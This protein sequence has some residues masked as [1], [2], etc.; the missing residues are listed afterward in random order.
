[1]T[2][3]KA[4]GAG[5]EGPRQASDFALMERICGRD[6]GALEEFYDRHASLV[7][8][9]CLRVLRDAREAEE[10]L[11]EV[12]LE[13]WRRVERY[14]AGRASPRVYL[15]QVSRSRALDRLRRNRRRSDL[16]RRA[17]AEADVGAD[18][19]ACADPLPIDDAIAAQD[20]QRIRS[21]LRAL[22]ESQRRA[23]MLA[24]FDGL[25]H[26][27]IAEALGEPL[28]TVKTRIRKG[29]LRMRELFVSL[30]EE[31]DR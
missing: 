19:A 2:A 21:V 27:E 10:V 20:A 31:E 14:D 29:L 6:P 28:G 9:I 23:L 24:F 8:A 12:F 7:Y 15:V 17:L 3:N 5:P 25:S 18:D 13:V 11:Q 22:P 4:P 16:G 1:M 26:S 30:F